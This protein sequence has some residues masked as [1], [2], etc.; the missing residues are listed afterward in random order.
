MEEVA[1]SGLQADDKVFPIKTYQI[2]TMSVLQYHEVGR[3][4]LAR[5]GFVNVV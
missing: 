1:R 5:L 2:M 4:C 3:Y